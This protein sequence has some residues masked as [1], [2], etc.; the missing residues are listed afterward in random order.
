MANAARTSLTGSV[1]ASQTTWTVVDASL[2]PPIGD[3]RLVCETEYALCTGRTGN[4]LTVTRG[5]EGSVAAPHTGGT[6]VIH[7][8]TKGGLDAYIAQ[9]GSPAGVGN[10]WF[11]NTPPPGWAILD[12]S[13][14][15]NAQTAY[16]V[17]WANV[18]PAWKSGADIILPDCRGR[19]PV[20]RGTHADVDTLGDNDGVAVASRRPRHS[21]PATG[22]TFTGT[23][24]NTGTE[25]ADHTHS[26]TTGTDSPDHAHGYTVDTSALRPYLD[27]ASA[28]SYSRAG[29]TGSS[30]GP[31][32]YGANARH[33]HAFTTGG[34]SAA[35]THGF[36]PA[37]S[38]GGAVGPA[39]MTDAPAHLVVNFII[40]L[41]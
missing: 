39:G 40:K 14:L 24:G 25:S 7:Q 30:G 29:G 35:H 36:T 8:L 31:A 28:A 2:F 41:A 15:T 4:V 22:L 5:I 18:D 13:T 16:P 12:G 23:A 37:G 17:L 9:A 3:F 1:D 38:I 26:G 33:T 32:T 6:A 34:R 10:L 20:G 27:V 11:S 19:V 21:H